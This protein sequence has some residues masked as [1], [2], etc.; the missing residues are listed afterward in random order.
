MQKVISIRQEMPL[1]HNLRVELFDVW[2]I[3]FMRPFVILYC[4]KYRF[5]VMDYVSKWV[6]ATAFLNNN[7]KVSDSWR[8]TSLQGLGHAKKI[9][10]DGGAHFCNWLFYALHDKYEVNYKEATV[11]HPPKSIQIDVSNQQIKSI[12]KKTMNAGWTN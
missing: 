4:N 8:N 12:L 2:G 9:L 1:K 7:T 5:M 6:D 11:C 3:D 10:S